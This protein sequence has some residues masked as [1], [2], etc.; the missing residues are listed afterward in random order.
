MGVQVLRLSVLCKPGRRLRVRARVRQGFQHQVLSCGRDTQALH[1]PRDSLRCRLQ[2]PVPPV[3]EA[4]RMMILAGR[5]AEEVGEC[6]AE[7]NAR[8]TPSRAAHGWAEG[9]ETS[10]GAGIAARK[11]AT[12]SAGARGPEDI[13]HKRSCGGKAEWVK[14]APA[15]NRAP[16]LYSFRRPRLIL[17]PSIRRSRRRWGGS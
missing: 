15:A 6:R 2:V 3:E 7:R 12:A 17:R 5:K 11:T 1:L 13:V 14:D 10:G 9:V 16:F 8:R 4:G